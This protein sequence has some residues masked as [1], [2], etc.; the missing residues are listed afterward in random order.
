ML[1]RSNHSSHFEFLVVEVIPQAHAYEYMDD[2]ITWYL[3]LDQIWYGAFV[4]RVGDGVR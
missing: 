3:S 1:E 4:L 2:V